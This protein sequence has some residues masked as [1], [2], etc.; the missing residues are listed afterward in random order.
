MTAISPIDQAKMETFMNR[1]VADY[2]ASNVMLMCHIRDRLGLFKAL[3]AH[4]PQR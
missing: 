4:G 1:L 3:D 2:A